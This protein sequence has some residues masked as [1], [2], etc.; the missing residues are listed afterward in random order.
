MK[1]LIIIGLFL[2]SCSVVKTPYKPKAP[3]QLT[4]CLK[5]VLNPT[6]DMGGVWTVELQPVLSIPLVLVGDN[7]CI[8]LA[9]HGCGLYK[10]K[11]TVESTTCEG[12][13]QS[14]TYNINYSLTIVGTS[15]C[16]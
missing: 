7:P 8:N 5:T 3:Q 13:T 6:A 12:C 11:Y 15:S 4:R 16:N 1:Y 14:V 10:L 9:N 2:T